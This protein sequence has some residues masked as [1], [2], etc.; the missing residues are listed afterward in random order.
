MNLFLIIHVAISLVGIVFGLI[1]LSGMLA[2]KRLNGL[3]LLFLTTTVATSLT[4]FLLPLN[5]FTPAVGVAIL[6]LLVLA[7]AGLARYT[8]NLQGAWRPAYVLGA[9]LAL[10]FNVFV[11]V[12]QLFQKVASLKTLAPTQSEPPFL[13][14]QAA[15][16]AL[17]VVLGIAALLRFHPESMLRVRAME[18]TNR[19]THGASG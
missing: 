15:T 7:L 11:L 6:S 18:S 9:T 13:I 17:F 16:L 3:T 2:G 12:V 14:A 8:Y 10:Y 19:K 1:V 4:G 5:G